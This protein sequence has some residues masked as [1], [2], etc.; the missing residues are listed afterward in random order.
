MTSESVGICYAV[1]PG[2]FS[3]SVVSCRLPERRALAQEFS[4]ASFQSIT[5][6]FSVMMMT[7]IQELVKSIFLVMNL[8]ETPVFG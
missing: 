7:S 2:T 5:Q 8:A 6:R 1:F 4:Y 3:V